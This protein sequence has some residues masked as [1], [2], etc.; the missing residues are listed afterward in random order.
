M[1][2]VK[3]NAGEALVKLRA[4]YTGSSKPRIISLYSQLTTLKIIY[5]EYITG[6]IT[7]D[8]KT[9]TAL[10]VAVETVSDPLLVA[11]VSNYI[12]FPDNYTHFVAIITQQKRI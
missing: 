11:I 10:D 4:N 8:G 6:N 3:V 12:P 7:G 1:R 2:D 5:S 9:A